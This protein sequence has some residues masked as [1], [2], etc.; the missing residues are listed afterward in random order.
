M[1][2]ELPHPGDLHHGRSGQLQHHPRHRRGV[3]RQRAAV[4]PDGRRPDQMA[5]P[6]RHPGGLSL[7]RGRV[8]RHLQADHQACGDD[9]AS[10]HGP[11][12]GHA[13]LQDRDHGTARSGRRLHAARC[14]EHHD[15]YRDAGPARLHHVNPS[16][17]P[18]PR[19]DRP[20]RGAAGQGRAPGDLRRHRRQQCARLG[21]AQGPRR[22]GADPGRHHLRRQGCVAREPCAEPRR[23]R[24]LGHRPWRAR[25]ERGRRASRHRWALQRPQHGRLVVLRFRGQA[26]ADPRRHR[27]G[28][29]RP[30][31]PG[32]DRHHQ[33]CEEGARR[34]PRGVEGEGSQARR[35]EVAEGHRGLEGSLA[36]R[37][38][39]ARH[40]RH[41]AAAL[42]APGKGSL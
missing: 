10:R 31:L 2:R 14:A 38:Q 7:R 15:R 8:P 18:R 22:D 30:R 25:G 19:R 13:R 27:S 11:A 39:A 16:A 24:P 17:G 42:R 26:E 12:L 20:R 1:R 21:R 34:H 6:R 36:G 9:D 4:L 23:G 29:D 41:R 35:L 3:L 5:R 28:R 33:R 32:R 40:F 37:G